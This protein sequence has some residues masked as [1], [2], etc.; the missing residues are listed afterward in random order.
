MIS[1]TVMIFYTTLRT[2]NITVMHIA[3]RVLS[4]D[5]DLKTWFLIYDSWYK[6]GG[7][8]MHSLRETSESRDCNSKKTKFINQSSSQVRLHILSPSFL[9]SSSSSILSSLSLLSL[10]A[11][12]FSGHYNTEALLAATSAETPPLWIVFVAAGTVLVYVVSI[13]TF[14]HQ[15][16]QNTKKLAHVCQRWVRQS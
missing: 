15:K 1:C 13:Y 14:V 6:H 4:N 11:W 10:F 12:K 3:M 9:L 8:G 2:C 7:E 5:S 16:S